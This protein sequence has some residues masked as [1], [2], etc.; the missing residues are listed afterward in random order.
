MSTVGC[1]FVEKQLRSIRPPNCID[2]PRGRPIVSSPRPSAILQ[3]A[4]MQLQCNS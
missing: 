2:H 3:P 4:T 1:R